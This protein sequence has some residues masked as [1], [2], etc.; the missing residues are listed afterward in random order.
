MLSL[1]RT[2]FL[3]LPFHLSYNKFTLTRNFSKEVLLDHTIQISSCNL[4]GKKIKVVK[5]S[6]SNKPQVLLTDFQNGTFIITINRPD[7]L[8]ALNKHVI[9]E[10]SKIID[11]I[12]SNTEI[13]TAIICGAGEKAL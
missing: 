13:K 2:N 6:S 12:Y 7:K 5:D 3:K 1:S 11:E 9:V 10:L 4:S 8:N